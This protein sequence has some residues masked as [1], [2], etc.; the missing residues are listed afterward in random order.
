LPRIGRDDDHSLGF[1]YARELV[2]HILHEGAKMIFDRLSRTLEN[3]AQN[4][5]FSGLAFC[6]GSG[7]VHRLKQRGN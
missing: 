1:V 7:A 4:D 2:G 3:N 6:L 5:S